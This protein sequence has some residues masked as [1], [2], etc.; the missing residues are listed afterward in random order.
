MSGEAEEMQCTCID[1]QEKIRCQ[2]RGVP[3][4]GFDFYVCERHLE[5]FDRLLEE[6]YGKR[7]E[8]HQNN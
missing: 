3:E 7:R 6:G 1:G 2:A 8:R 5:M 4:P